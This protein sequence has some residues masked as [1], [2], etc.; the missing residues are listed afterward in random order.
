MP[1]MFLAK[2]LVDT[3]ATC[4]CVDPSVMQE[5]QIPP[6]GKTTIL[7]PLTSDGPVS[8]TQ[9]DMALRIYASPS[10]HPLIV[11]NLAVIESA[12]F[13]QQGF[14]ALIGRDV[15]PKCVL[16]FNGGAGLYT[17]AF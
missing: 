11:R 7:T 17:L 3:G 5:L 12:L 4:T 13:D 8:A 14:H 15:L 6:S 16:V 9:Y 1:G 10:Q 2:G